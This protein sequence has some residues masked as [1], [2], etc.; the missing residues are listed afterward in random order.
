MTNTTINAETLETFRAENR[1]TQSDLA[2][3]L[4]Y[5]R[6]MIAQ[7]ENGNTEMTP[8]IQKLV[9]YVIEEVTNG[10]ERTN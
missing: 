5:S 4:G 2:D 10:T 9:R 6:S 1:I 3:K 7:I 8:R